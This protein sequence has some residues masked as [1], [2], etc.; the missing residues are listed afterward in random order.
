MGCIQ[1]DIQIGGVNGAAMRALAQ[2]ANGDCASRVA[3]APRCL[4]ALGTAL[5]QPAVSGEALD[6]LLALTT[7][8]EAAAL[9]PQHP[10]VVAELS[11]IAKGNGPEAARALRLLA[12]L[13]VKNGWTTPVIALACAATV[14]LVIKYG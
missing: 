13:D 4:P 10:D 5:R 11:A 3:R 12:L 6:A 2:L 14:F 1:P 8:P 7:S 9:V